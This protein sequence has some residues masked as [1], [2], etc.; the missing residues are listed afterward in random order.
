M[1][2]C[3]DGI[4]KT[5]PVIPKTVSLQ[6]I[7]PLMQGKYW[8]LLKPEEKTRTQ[9]RVYATEKNSFPSLEINSSKEVGGVTL[10]QICPQRPAATQTELGETRQ[11]FQSLDGEMSSADFISDE[12]RSGSDALETGMAHDPVLDLMYG[13]MFTSFVQPMSY[14][15]VP[16]P[17]Y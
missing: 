11:P 6:V 3:V 13:T 9:T 17:G 4:V 7:M 8:D 15:A 1:Q 10:G 16:G 5:W 14:D 12:M 2:P